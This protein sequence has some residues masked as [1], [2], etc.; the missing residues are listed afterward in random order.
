M[1]RR[2]RAQVAGWGAYLPQRVMTNDD[3]AQLVD[4]SDAW[5]RER[6]G[7]AQRRIAAPDE[8]TASM[9]TRA[10]E[11]AL[12]SAG[13]DPA[14][15]DLI[16]V[17][18]VTPDYPFPATACLVQHNLGASRAGAFDLEAGCSGFVYGL[19]MAAAAIESGTARQALVIGAETLSR[20][21]DW[22]DRNTCILFGDGAG[23]IVLRA[24]AG[25]AEVVTSVLGADGGG[26]ESL[27]FPGGGARFPASADTLAKGLHAVRM[28][29]RQIFKFATRIVPTIVRQL[30]DRAGL[31]LD[32]LDWLILHQANA[33]IMESAAERLKLPPE[34]VFSNI[35]RYGNTS[36]ASI[37]IALCEAASQGLL[38]PGQ[39][40]ALVGFGAG[41][42]WAGAL[43]EWHGPP[44]IRR[45]RRWFLATVR[46][47]WA[48]IRR[49]VRQLR[50]R[51]VRPSTH[52]V[53]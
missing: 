32:Q 47:V 26:G 19:V 50:E 30:L 12:F 10:A 5:I 42:T 1:S 31:T 48:G 4:T 9:A 18:T 24:T 28:D 34:R 15:T 33:R 37:P 23:A 36:A 21:V 16:I 11:A 35:E 29:G 40:V 13:A 20:L 39:H 14:A 8:C 6:T 51:W 25:A 22:K 43:L 53:P 52:K 27:I 46:L 45:D 2:L 49:R 3:L 17:A 7:I 38:K 41:L 44:A